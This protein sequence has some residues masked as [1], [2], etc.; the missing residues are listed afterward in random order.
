MHPYNQ[1][2]RHSY[3]VDSGLT[4]ADAVQGTWSAS[5]SAA[6]I[7]GRM[8]NR[9]GYSLQPMRTDPMSNSYPTA[10]NVKFAQAI[11]SIALC[12]DSGI[13]GRF[14]ENHLNDTF[15][16]EVSQALAIK[17]DLKTCEHA[18]KKM[19]EKLIKS[20]GSCSSLQALQA[21]AAVYGEV[22]DPA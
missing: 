21:R 9:K 20:G 14:M 13:I 11:S 5:D 10:F 8:A 15:K 16:T 19:L 7:S 3:G 22:A 1:R 2:N 6:G 17:L 4:L 18:H 12:R